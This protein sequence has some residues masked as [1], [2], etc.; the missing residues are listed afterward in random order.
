MT[1]EEVLTILTPYLDMIIEAVNRGMENFIKDH[2]QLMGKYEPVDKACLI[3][4]YVKIEVRNLFDNVSGI[5]IRKTNSL[6]YLIVDGTIFLRFKKLRK[7]H[8]P[9][10]QKTRQSLKFAKQYLIAEQDY[11]PRLFPNETPICLDF[12]NI[13]VGYQLDK[14]GIRINKI[15]LTCQSGLRKN[16]WKYNIYNRNRITEPVPPAIMNNTQTESG[17]NIR[18]K[19][20]RGKEKEKVKNNEA[21][22]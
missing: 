17:P 7:N 5:S 12:G 4:T 22:S 19:A 15:F 14:L 6:V 1:Q 16:K 13:N 10:N 20:N 9:S 8:L 2:N 3:N 11:I 21:A 18:V